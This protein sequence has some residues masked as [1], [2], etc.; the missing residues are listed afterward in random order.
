MTIDFRKCLLAA[1]F[2]LGL[3]SGPLGAQPVRET[4]QGRDYDLIQPAQSTGSPDKVEVIEFF[5]YACP[6]CYHFEPVI[7]KW[8]QRLPADVQFKRFPLSAGPAWSPTAKLFFALDAMGIES[9]LH[10]DVFNAIHRDRSLNPNDESAISAWV[11]QRGVDAGKF[12]IAYGFSGPKLQQM[13]R[14]FSAYGVAG[15]PAIVVDGKYRVRNEAVKSYE[16]LMA[17]TDALI[18]KSRAERPKPKSG[19]KARK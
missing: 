6:H 16:D 9:R 12:N 19:G 15:V 17:L 3:T 13:Q 8:L 1:L 18:E 5:S 10:G 11:A 7:G 4:V 2:A 14:T